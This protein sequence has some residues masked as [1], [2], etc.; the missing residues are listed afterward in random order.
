MIVDV[1]LEEQTHSKE[2]R[3][4]GWAT[5]VKD[6]FLKVGETK[7]SSGSDGSLHLQIRYFLFHSEATE[8]AARE[9]Y[10]YQG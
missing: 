9:H 4:P 3:A 7:V 8:E 10:F 1:L 6:R 5:G 2:E